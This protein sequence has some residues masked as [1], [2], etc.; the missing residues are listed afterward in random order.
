MK[1]KTPLAGWIW[2]ISKTLDFDS[3]FCPFCGSSGIPG[4][5]KQQNKEV[6]STD[7]LS[8]YFNESVCLIEN[9]DTKLDIFEIESL[10]G[11]NE[12]ITQYFEGIVAGFS[13]TP[14]FGA[15]LDKCYANIQS[16]E[17]NYKSALSSTIIAHTIMYLTSFDTDKRIR[18][19]EDDWISAYRYY[20]LSL[21]E[22]I[23]SNG[24]TCLAYNKDA[25]E[26][27][28]DVSTNAMYFYLP[29]A[30]GATTLDETEILCEIFNSHKFQQ[31]MA[32]DISSRI[33]SGLGTGIEDEKEYLKY[34]KSFLDSAEHIGTW[35]IASNDSNKSINEN[36]ETM[37]K[38]KKRD[39]QKLSKRIFY[40][41]EDFHDEFLF[42]AK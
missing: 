3:I 11:P 16:I 10:I 33:I 8:T 31:E 40:S 22:R 6:I 21:N 4:L 37:I 38:E 25:Q 30:A 23:F 35:I 9:D 29:S 41:N 42:I 17:H 27:I 1:S 12:S 20:A 7:V 36:I 18:M 15:W 13:L 19:A 2:E 14:E 39:F 26:L 24:K 28:H 5:F 34:F 32:D